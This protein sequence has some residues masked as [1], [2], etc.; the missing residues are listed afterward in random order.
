MALRIAFW[1]IGCLVFLV[2]MLLCLISKAPPAAY[3]FFLFV[4]G[5]VATTTVIFWL[6]E[7][8]RLRHEL[9]HARQSLTEAYRKQYPPP[10]PTLEEGE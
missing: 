10:I 4:A 3:G 2:V 8:E 1:I 6:Q 7:Q 9:E 5:V